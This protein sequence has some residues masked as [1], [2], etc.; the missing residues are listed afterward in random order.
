MLEGLSAR[1]LRNLALFYATI[2]ITYLL[3]YR[4][5]NFMSIGFFTVVTYL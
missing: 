4:T 5:G 1:D 3:T 2:L